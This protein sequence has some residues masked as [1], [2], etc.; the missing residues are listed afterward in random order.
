MIGESDKLRIETKD[1]LC[2]DGIVSNNQENIAAEIMNEGVII[3]AFF[4]MHSHLGES[5][6]KSISGD[7]WTIS[8]YLEYTEKYNAELSKEE[9]DSVWLESARYTA[10]Q[11]YAQGTLGF[12]AARSSS[13][14]KEFNLL[15][16]SGY[17]IMNSRKLID[18]KNAGLNGFIA[19]MNENKSVAGKVGVFL[20]SIY[21]NDAE[22]FDFA[23]QC[24]KNGADF[25]TVHVSED[26]YTSEMEKKRHNMSAIELLDKYGLLSDKT[27]LVHCGCCSDEDLLLIKE[28]HAIIC[29]CPISN[30][31]LNTRMVNLYKLEEIGIP[32]CIATD[33]IGTGRTFSLLEQIKHA[34][35]EYPDIPLARYWSS[36]TI[37]P[38]FCYKGSLYTGRIEVGVRSSF[39][40]TD[41]ENNDVN[42]LIE[43]LVEGKIGFKPIR[44]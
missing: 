10:R 42:E 21:S 24:I 30:R 14:A 34:R 13:I 4:N 25:I 33:G 19:Y 3:P 16:M 15:T 8:R 7:D 31:F 23:R 43:G 36:I 38:G 28:R 17:P 35:S 2:I 29:V 12:C 40:L 6:F 41:Y 18:F 9:R 44:L 32:W 26:L 5:I 22:S 11:M 27:V 20:H 37:E 39:L 1:L